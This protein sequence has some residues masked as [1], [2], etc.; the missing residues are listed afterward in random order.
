[1]KQPTKYQVA[2]RLKKGDEVMIITGKSAGQTGKIERIDRKKLRVYVSGQNIAKRHTR[3][4]MSDQVGGIIDKVMP[5]AISNVMIVD[6]KTQEPTRIGYKVEDN[7]KVR[8]AKKSGTL[9]D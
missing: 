3:P 6:P 2:C 5:I 7:K 9:L 1:M 4:S 8:F